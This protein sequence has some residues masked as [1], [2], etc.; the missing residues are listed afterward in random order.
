VPS[1]VNIEAS[2]LRTLQTIADP[3]H[4]LVNLLPDKTDV[5]QHY[6]FRRHY[7]K[8]LSKLS[9]LYDSNLI[10]RM[11]YQQSYT[12]TFLLRPRQ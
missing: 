8:P 11:L 1:E 10:V 6:H 3:S 5:G 12:L 9:K 4:V 2:V 7:T